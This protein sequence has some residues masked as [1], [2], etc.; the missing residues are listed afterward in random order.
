VLN[1]KWFP[2]TN[3]SFHYTTA[4]H[5]KYSTNKAVGTVF[6]KLCKHVPM[7]FEGVVKMFQSSSIRQKLCYHRGGRKSRAFNLTKKTETV[8][9]SDR[10]DATKSEIGRHHG[11]TESVELKGTHFTLH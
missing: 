6:G 4:V 11:L 3:V 2:F 8:S 9:A 10:R 5:K 1:R 7:C